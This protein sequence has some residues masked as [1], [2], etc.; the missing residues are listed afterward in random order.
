MPATMPWSTQVGVTVN[1][2]DLLR[3]FKKLSCRLRDCFNYLE[4]FS[5]HLG[6]PALELAV[7]RLIVGQCADSGANPFVTRA[8]FGIHSWVRAKHV[9]SDDRVQVSVRS[10]A[11]VV[12]CHR[13]FRV[14]KILGDVSSF[15]SLT[16]AHNRQLVANIWEARIRVPLE[17]CCSTL[18]DKLHKH[19]VVT[20]CN[21]VEIIMDHLSVN[22]NS[23]TCICSIQI[24]A[25]DVNILAFL[26]NPLAV[27]SGQQD[28]GV[29]QN[30]TA[31][32]T[33][34]RYSICR[35]LLGASGGT[36]NDSGNSCPAT[37]DIPKKK[38]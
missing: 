26:E 27:T 10:F 5:S 22:T 1:S 32:I 13:D 17:R 19:E 30:G 35:V 9:A 2:H 33:C 31:K 4:S 34:Y 20:E 36:S 37:P 11:E 23:L 3:K 12:S 28:I 6:L 38:E 18:F 8:C 16:V 25:S 15:R 21:G 7:T 24:R 14:K 29:N